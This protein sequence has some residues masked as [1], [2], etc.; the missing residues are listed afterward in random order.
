MARHKCCKRNK[1]DK[2]MRRNYR[3]SLN[4]R[5]RRANNFSQ[6]RPNFMVLDYFDEFNLR[7]AGVYLNGRYF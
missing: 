1:F 5:I 4:R 7:E 3:R 2:L 6:G